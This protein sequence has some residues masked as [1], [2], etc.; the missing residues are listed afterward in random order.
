MGGASG[1]RKFFPALASCIRRWQVVPFEGGKG[2]RIHFPGRMTPCAE[3]LK[4]PTTQV[5]EQGF[6]HDAAGGIP[7]AEKAR[8]TAT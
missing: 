4:A 6:G 2:Q 1:G 8:Y 3:S 7:G 5:V